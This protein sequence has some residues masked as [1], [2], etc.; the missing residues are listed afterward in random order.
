[1]TDKEI[2]IRLLEDLETQ[3]LHSLDESREDVLE[4]AK[5]ELDK[6]QTALKWARQQK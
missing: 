6:V 3:F 5:E 2:A 4:I 1:M